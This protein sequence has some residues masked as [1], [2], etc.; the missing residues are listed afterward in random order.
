MEGEGLEAL[1]SGENR[2]VWE[3]KLQVAQNVARMRGV[4]VW[5]K[6]KPSVHKALGSIP[7]ITKIK[8]F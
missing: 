3:C 2:Y 5:G 6:H 8:I 4:R 1:R 7:G